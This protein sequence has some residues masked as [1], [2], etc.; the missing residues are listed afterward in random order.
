MPHVGG[1]GEPAGAQVQN[2]DLGS[3]RFTVPYCLQLFPSAAFLSIL[4]PQFP[5]VLTCS[6]TLLSAAP[7][8]PAPHGCLALKSRPPKGSSFLPQES[9]VISAPSVEVS[10]VSRKTGV[11]SAPPT[12]DSAEFRASRLAQ[13]SPRDFASFSTPGPCCGT[14]QPG[15][16]SAGP[17]LLC[18]VPWIIFLSR[19]QREGWQGN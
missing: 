8:P 2:W 3:T 13:V 1:A 18:S 19:P 14:L 12:L 15:G 10:L 7:A 6:T 16:P 9:P 11:S 17:T 5:R 4:E